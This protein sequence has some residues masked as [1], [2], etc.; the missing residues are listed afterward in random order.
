M[1]IMDTLYTTYNFFNSHI[2]QSRNFIKTMEKFSQEVQ[3]V[4]SQ[5]LAK[6]GLFIVAF[7][8]KDVWDFYIP[9]VHDTLIVYIRYFIF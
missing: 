3:R 4:A 5:D 9:Y 6:V 2:R 7:T 8:I 1:G